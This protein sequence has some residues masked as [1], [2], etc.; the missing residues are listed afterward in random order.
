MN[1]DLEKFLKLN[2]LIPNTCLDGLKIEEPFD[3]T[4]CCQ[5]LFLGIHDIPEITRGPDYLIDYIER[6]ES[7]LHS[8]IILQVVI[9][10]PE[11]SLFKAHDE[12]FIAI[13]D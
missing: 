7:L 9:M 6:C 5:F 12:M 10:L 2:S 3:G 4:I 8:D 11:N 13:N 1:F